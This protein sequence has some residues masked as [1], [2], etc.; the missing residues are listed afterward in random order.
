MIL[1]N[2][3][4]PPALV[5]VPSGS[6]CAGDSAR[7][8]ITLKEETCPVKRGKQDGQ[9]ALQ[10]ERAVGLRGKRGGPAAEWRARYAVLDGKQY[11]KRVVQ[12]AARHARQSASGG[13]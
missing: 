8:H 4:C 3:L 6:K 5:R 10:N 1:H 2:L 7:G 13:R 12:F 11:E 9:S